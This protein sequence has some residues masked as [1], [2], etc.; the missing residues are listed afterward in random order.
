[1]SGRDRPFLSWSRKEQGFDLQ[2]LIQLYLRP[3][4]SETRK[5]TVLFCNI[6]PFVLALTRGLSQL[7][8]RARPIQPVSHNMH[9]AHCGR[10]V[11]QERRWVGL[12][13]KPNTQR[14]SCRV[15]DIL[16][17]RPCQKKLNLKEEFQG[18]LTFLFR[19]H[20]FIFNKIAPRSSLSFE[21][22]KDSLFQKKMSGPLKGHE[23]SIK[24]KV[25]GP[26]LWTT[27]AYFRKPVFWRE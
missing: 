3:L 12:R 22:K 15:F 8:R 9:K 16:K 14:R 19:F 23:S 21:L 5:L 4:F 26:V 27:T 10:A 1:M 7:L 11:R 2:S 24:M 6:F 25:K 13:H 18:F 17:V 20:P